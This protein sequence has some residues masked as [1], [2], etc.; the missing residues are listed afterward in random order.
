MRRSFRSFCL[1]PGS[2]TSVCSCFGQTV[3]LQSETRKK[4][5]R[6]CLPGTVSN[7]PDKP[8][9]KQALI[10][11]HPYRAIGPCPVFLFPFFFSPQWRSV[12]LTRFIGCCEFSGRANVVAQLIFEKKLICSFQLLLPAPIFRSSSTLGKQRSVLR[13]SAP[14]CPGPAHPFAAH[15]VSCAHTHARIPLSLKLQ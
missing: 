11:P 4:N 10:G 1:L 5:Y 3:K 15:S 9:R 12:F 6:P 8:R 7:W 14:P 13:P 2:S